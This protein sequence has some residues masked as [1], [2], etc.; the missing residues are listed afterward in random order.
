MKHIAV[1]TYGLCC[2]LDY[3]ITNNLIS[4]DYETGIV[5][6]KKG[7]HGNNNNSRKYYRVGVYLPHRVCVRVGVYQLIAFM[8]YGYDM[9]GYQID[10]INNKHGLYDNNPE[11]LQLLSPKE[12]N[13]KNMNKKIK[14]INR[15]THEETIYIYISGK[16]A[17][18]AL[19]LSRGHISSVAHGNRNY[20]GDYYFRFI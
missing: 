14:A 5:T 15:F 11:N 8:K 3:I 20:T 16:E 1:N 19:G 18:I 7:T 2:S 17:S 10:H 6:T 12:N 9:V 4:I 13:S